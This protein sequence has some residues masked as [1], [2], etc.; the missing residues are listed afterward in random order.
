MTLLL[1]GSTGF[2]G[3]HLRKRLSKKFRLIALVRPSSL[4]GDLTSDGIQQIIFDGDVRE[5]TKKMER[6]SVSGVV[7]LASHYLKDHGPY[8]INTLVDSNILFST[9]VLEAVASK[10]KWFLNTGSF[11]QH[12]QDSHYSPVNLYAATKQAFQDIAKYYQGIYE[13]QF[14]TLTLSDT[15]GPHDTRPKIL[16]LW[17]HHARSGQQLKMSGGE[18]LLD[19]NYIDNVIDAFDVLIEQLV[20]E[21]NNLE[22]EYAVRA[23]TIY[24][25]KELASIFEKV[26]GNTVPIQWGVVPYKQREVMKPWSGGVTV[27]GWS[28]AISIE[29]GIKR[30]FKEFHE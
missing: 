14:V 27:P 19:I 23:K 21:N 9:Q 15:F 10:A 22:S 4:T 25:L 24:S 11:F 30:T 7:H 26:T 18:Q 16:N 29:E 3:Y 28:P 2:I 17:Q 1:T 8:D 12:Y 5:L 6:Y 20:S 13:L